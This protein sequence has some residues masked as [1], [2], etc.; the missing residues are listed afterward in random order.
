MIWEMDISTQERKMYK[1]N[2][3]THG[4][5]IIEIIKY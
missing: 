2:I 4:T 5:R 1:Y 3:N